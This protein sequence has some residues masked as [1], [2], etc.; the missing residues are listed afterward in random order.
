MGNFSSILK[1][2]PYLISAS[3][4]PFDFVLNCIVIDLNLGLP[5][6]KESTCQGRRYGFD[7]CVGKIPVGRK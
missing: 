3:L 5:S 6:G 4:L 7:A 1:T 2:F